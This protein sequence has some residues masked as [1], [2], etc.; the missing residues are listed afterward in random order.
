MTT[1]LVPNRTSQ[2]LLV[3]VEPWASEYRLAANEQLRIEVAAPSCP[4][5]EVEYQPD[6]SDRVVVVAVMN[7]AG[8]TYAADVESLASSMPTRV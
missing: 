6:A 2:Q 7:P 3:I 8:A 1:L 4:T 5:I